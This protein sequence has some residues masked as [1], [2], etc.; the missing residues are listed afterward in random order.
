MGIHMRGVSGVAAWDSR[1]QGVE[2]WA[3]EKILKKILR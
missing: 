1:V 3:I 2:K